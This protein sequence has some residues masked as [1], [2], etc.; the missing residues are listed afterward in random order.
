MD[1][2]WWIYRCAVLCALLQEG[3]GATVCG[4][5]VRYNENSTCRLLNAEPASSS[6][7][8]SMISNS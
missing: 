8:L 5:S 2:R 4:R 6:V 7:S 1:A 3:T